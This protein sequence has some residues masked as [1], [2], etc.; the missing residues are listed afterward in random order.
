MKHDSCFMFLVSRDPVT[1]TPEM[2]REWLDAN[3]GVPFNSQPHKVDQY[4]R[5]MASGHWPLTGEGIRF[6]EADQLVDGRHR[7]RACVKSG[8][9]FLTYVTR[10]SGTAV[11]PEPPVA[12]PPMVSAMEKLASDVKQR[13]L[14]R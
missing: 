1:V 11:T 3:T 6:D 9:P 8:V 14:G 2:A 5:D 7:L 13:F 10:L 4:A 12:Q